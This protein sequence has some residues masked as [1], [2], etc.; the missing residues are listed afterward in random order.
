MKTMRRNHIAWFLESGDLAPLVE[1]LVEDAKPRRTHE[2]RQHATG[3]VFVKYF[4][5]KG[6]VGHVR[7]LVLPRGKREY[8]LGKRLSAQSIPTPKPLGYGRGKRGSF[9]LL[10][11]LEAKPFESAFAESSQRQQLLDGLALLLRQLREE[12]VRHNDLHLENV[13]A[14][15][16][17]LY[18]IDLHKTSMAKVRF[19]RADELLNLTHALTMIYDKMTEAEKDRFFNAYGR[20]EVRP[21]AEEGL[22]GLR[23]RWIDSKKRR[24]FCATS[25]LMVSK[26]RIYVR[27]REGSSEGAFREM[28]KTD[29]KVRVE[30]WSDHVRKTYYSRRRLR[31]AWQAHAVL[32]YLEM[33]VVPRA[34]YMQRA[35]LF[36]K[37]YIAMEDLAGKGEELDRFLDRE[38]DRMES[39]ERRL[40]VGSLSSFFNRLLRQGIAHRDLKACNVFVL[41]VGFKLLDVEDIWFI[42]P[43]EEILER[44]LVQLN[45]SVP[46]RIAVSD[47]IRFFLKTTGGF[48]FDRK[49]LFRKVMQASR[50]EEIVYEGATGLRKESW[51][52]HRQGSRS[53]FSL[54]RR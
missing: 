29:R 6:I 13:M 40:F 48:P 39:G 54:S 19:S 47:R 21:S 36:R 26:N 38:Y 30:R 42:D 35:S 44:M 27:G 11:R 43:S 9:V 49:R 32:E 16:D 4:V 14:A 2:I 22:L 52:G 51:Q 41:S 34:A 18:L 37:G 53:P 45:T 23:R 28:I 33:D 31:R 25:K 3:D 8:L 12:R 15:P 7:N 10:E 17:G 46:A 24:A 20:P 5:E 50:G 1:G